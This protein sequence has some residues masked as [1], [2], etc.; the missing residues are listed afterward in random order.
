MRARLRELLVQYDAAQDPHSAAPAPRERWPEG[1]ALAVAMNSLK[2]DVSESCLKVVHH[3]LVIC[4][5]AGYK[6][7]TEYSV[8]R[9]LRDIYSAQLMISNDR[10]V[11]TTGAL[12]LAQRS[13]IGAL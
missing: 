1:M 4:G 12:L 2:Y 5:M 3:A 6:N 7:G 10:V 9:H 11:M 8:G 13:E